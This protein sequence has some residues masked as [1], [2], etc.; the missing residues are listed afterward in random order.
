MEFLVSFLIILNIMLGTA[1]FVVRIGQRD[2]AYARQVRAE[3]EV[4]PYFRG[5]RQD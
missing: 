4:K 1:L 2:A 3:D 5:E